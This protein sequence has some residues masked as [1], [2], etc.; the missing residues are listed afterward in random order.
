MSAGSSRQPRAT[1]WGTM[2]SSRPS[3]PCTKTVAPRGAD[4]LTLDMEAALPIGRDGAVYYQDFDGAWWSEDQW[5]LYGSQDG[6]WV[7]KDADEEGDSE[8]DAALAHLQEEQPEIEKQRQE[9]EAMMA[10]KDR[11]LQKPRR[12]VAAAV[13]DHGWGGGVAQRPFKPTSTYMAKGKRGGH[14][15][16]GHPKGKVNYSEEARFAKSGGKNKG[17]WNVPSWGKGK[18]HKGGKHKKG[19]TNYHLLTIDESDYVLAA[20][21]RAN[22]LSASES[23]V[24]TGGPKARKP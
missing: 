1:S 10:E 12:A 18:G 14:P 23:L 17:K 7:P 19:G 4:L 11:N 22:P 6:E 16:G 24:D 20:A 8:P 15:K 3:S 13:K 9:I 21:E 5:A 2:R